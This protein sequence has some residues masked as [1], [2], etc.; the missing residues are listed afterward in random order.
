MSDWNG[1]QQ[2]VDLKDSRTVLDSS[3]MSSLLNGTAFILDSH[4]FSSAS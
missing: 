2:A 4:V 3:S 1:M